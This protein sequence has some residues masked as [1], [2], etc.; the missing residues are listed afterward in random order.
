VRGHLDQYLTNRSFS[1]ETPLYK[2]TYET[3]H[4][5]YNKGTVVMHQL[6]QLIGEEAVNTALKSLFDKH[7]YPNPPPTSQDLL[8][9]LHHP[10]IEELFKQIIIYESKIESVQCDSTAVAFRLITQKFNEDGFGK[11]TKATPD[12]TIEIGL[13]TDDE[14]LQ[15]QSFIIKNGIAA[16]TFITNKK[17]VRLVIDPYIKT[18]GS[19][20]EAPC[21]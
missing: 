11:R 4:L 19:Y 2:T 8:N 7:A 21:H 14:K 18:M 1:Q 13:Y 20:K 10:K 17:P 15:V 9:E 12:S 16:G 6:K 5:P 3:P